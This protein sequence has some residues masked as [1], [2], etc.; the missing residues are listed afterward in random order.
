VSERPPQE[1]IERVEGLVG[2][3]VTDWVRA[4]GGYTIAE[5]WSLGLANGTRVFAKMA[6]TDDIAWRIRDEHRHM[7]SFTED[8]RCGI[9]GWEDGERPLLLLEDLSHAHW[10]P[11]W[12][13]GD[14]DRV[15]EALERVWQ[16]PADHLR[17]SAGVQGMFSGWRDVAN[18]PTGFLGLRIGSRDWLDM[19]LPTLIDAA[20]GA[21]FEGDDFVHMDVRSD[22]LCFDG[23][24]VVFVDW[25]WAVRGNRELDLSCWLPSLRLEGGPLPEEVEPGMGAHAAGVSGYFAA[26]APL[27]EPEG[28][29]TV[30]RFQLRQL[31]ISLPWACRELGL[32]QP[33]VAY[34]REEIAQL[35]RHL[36]A[37]SIDDAEWHE[38]T[39]EVLIDA[40]LRL[41][42]PARAVGQGRRR[43][44]MAVG[45]GT[46][47]RSLS[48]K[49]DL[50]RR[51]LRER[52]PDGEHGALGG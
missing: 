25:N 44:G 26:N 40:Y 3:R 33:D 8:F 23:S 28:A 6:P 16:M 10:P 37:G 24:R 34:A 49:S 4:T 21:V 52:L 29:P 14:V 42:R 39:E 17:A 13:P 43:G 2:S 36:D 51:R 12:R 18:D 41:R 35:D 30:R 48:R 32:P 50:P 20:E 1:L 15:R 27:P 31:R 5:R 7:V 9:V 46:R 38:R 45:A 47:A 22:N 11:E 19:C